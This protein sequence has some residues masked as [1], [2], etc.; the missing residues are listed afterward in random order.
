MRFYGLEIGRTIHK[1]L[2]WIDTEIVKYMDE[3]LEY[4]NKEEVDACISRGGKALELLCRQLVLDLG[5]KVPDR[6]TL[7]SFYS[8]QSKGGPSL[9]YESLSRVADISDDEKKSFIDRVVKGTWSRNKASHA[10]PIPLNI[11][12]LGDALQLLNNIALLADWVGKKIYLRKETLENEEMIPVFLS[13]GNPHRLDQIQFL[14]KI[15]AFMAN[16]KIELINLTSQ[17]YSDEKPY[18]QIRELMKKCNAA[19]IVGWERYHAYTL[20]ER[21][22]SK[23]EKLFQGKLLPTSWNH[24]EGSMAMVLDL[25][26]IILREAN[27]MADGIF[28]DSSSKQK[29]YSFNLSKESQGLSEELKNILDG[30]VTQKVFSRSNSKN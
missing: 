11:P 29:I 8:D 27:L 22:R 26:T 5:C 19:L 14:S 17:K 1:N 13:V 23:E 24:I 16:K 9:L 12:T 2:G 25:P 10:D 4:F 15:Q 18:E 21:E 20:F 3:A 30:W 7:G 28:D 6:A